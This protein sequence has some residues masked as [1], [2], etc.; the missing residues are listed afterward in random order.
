MIE[1]SNVKLNC[2]VLVFLYLEILSSWFKMR[3]VWVTDEMSDI[4]CSVTNE[5]T[6]RS[7]L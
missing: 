3:W 1:A 4:F 2:T 5:W 6:E 7:K